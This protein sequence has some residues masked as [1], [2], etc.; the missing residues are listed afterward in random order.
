M[1]CKK[2]RVRLSSYLD[3][4]LPKEESIRIESHLQ[5]CPRCAEEL[6]SLNAMGRLLD[7]LPGMEIPPGFEQRLTME[8]GRRMAR[9]RRIVLSDYRWL[10]GAAAKIAAVLLLATGLA[11]GG[12]MGGSVSGTISQQR[13]AASVQEPELDLQSAFAPADPIAAAYLQIAEELN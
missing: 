13:A 1:T 4:E 7:G 8:A 9:Q 10:E 6:D 12:V 2:V 11:V 5:A 3:G